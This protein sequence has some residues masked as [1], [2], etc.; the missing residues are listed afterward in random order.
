[1]SLKTALQKYGL[2]SV[3]NL[4]KDEEID[5]EDFLTMSDENDF[6]EI[7]TDISVDRIYESGILRCSLCHGASVTTSTP[8]AV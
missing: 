1:M 6:K 4:F 7:G 5:L 8:S 3:Y 2:S